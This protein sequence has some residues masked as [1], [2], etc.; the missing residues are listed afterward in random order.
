MWACQP[1]A[2]G[3]VERDGVKVHDELFGAGEPTVLLLPTWSIVHSRLWKMQIHYLARHCP[4]LTSDPRGNGP[5][6]RPTEPKAYAEQE[7]AADA[8]AVMDATQTPRAVVV[9]FPDG[10]HRGL[11]S[12]R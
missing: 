12:S 1:V 8:L 2:D 10:A 3:Y 11:L 5:S 4:V 9:G 6:D 7:F